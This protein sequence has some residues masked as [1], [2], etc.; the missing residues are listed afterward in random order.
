MPVEDQGA[1][2]NQF[3]MLNEGMNKQHTD[4][5]RFPGAGV[6][7]S[8]TS[9]KPQESLNHRAEQEDQFKLS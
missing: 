3:C 9:G 6:G 5:T 4:S 8:R 2:E 1:Q 7:G